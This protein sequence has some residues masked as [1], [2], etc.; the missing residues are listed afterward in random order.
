MYMYYKI[1]SSHLKIKTSLKEIKTTKYCKI[2]LV[3]M[4]Y[5]LVGLCGK[6]TRTISEEQ[7][8]M[9]F[10]GYFLER[11]DLK[12]FHLFYQ[13]RKSA[14]NGPPPLQKKRKMF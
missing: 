3:L 12:P 13:N 10:L 5:I 7:F 6:K 11:N 14:Y 4:Q 2:T 8:L 1:R 9:S